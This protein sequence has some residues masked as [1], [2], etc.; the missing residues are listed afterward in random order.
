M[1]TKS[2]AH[3]LLKGSP[4]EPCGLQ[5]LRYAR[6]PAGDNHCHHSRCQPTGCRVSFSSEELMKIWRSKSSCINYQSCRRGQSED[7]RRGGATEIA[8]EC[9]CLSSF[10]SARAKLNQTRINSLTPKT[11]N[12]TTCNPRSSVLGFFP[13]FCSEFLTYETAASLCPRSLNNSAFI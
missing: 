6:K 4:C 1:L 9:T 10:V 13:G 7:E 11:S 12:P 8:K 3:N 2:E 5:L